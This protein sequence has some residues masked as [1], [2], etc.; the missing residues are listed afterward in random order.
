MAT[1]SEHI[2]GID[3]GTTNSSVAVV[4]DGRLEEIPVDGFRTMPSAVGLDPTGRLLVGRSAKNQQISHPEATVTSI[5]RRMGTAEKVVLAERSFSPEEISAIILGHLKSAAETHLGCP[6]TKAVITV[7]AFFNEQQRKATQAAGEL[8]GFQVMRIINEPTAAALAYGA[9]SAAR[10]GGTLLVYDLGGGTFDVSVVSI[11]NGIVEVR[12]S[13]GDTHLGGDDFDETLV[14]LA[15]KRFGSE[16]GSAAANALPRSAR[17]RLKGVMEAAKIQL[18]D[19]PFAAVSEEYL[20]A[21]HHLRTEI[22]RSAYEELIEPLIDRTLNSLQQALADAKLVPAD[23]D[24]IMLVGGAT[25]TPLVHSILRHRLGMEP[26]HEIDPDL[27]V[28]MGAAVQGAALAGQPA[29]AVL[30]DITAHGYSTECL[31]PTFGVLMC[32]PLIRR[33][34]PLP[35]RKTE[36]FSTVHA[37]QAEVEVLV[38][39]GEDPVPSRNLELGRFMV[40]GLSPTAPALSPVTICFALDLNGLLTATATEKATGLSRSVTLDTRGQHRLNLDAAR[41][42]LAA[43]FAET[44]DAEDEGDDGEDAFEEESET[45]SD[46]DGADDPSAVAEDGGPAPA[47]LL[48]SAKNLRQ[49]AEALLGR[50]LAETDAED[51]RRRLATVAEAIKN[52]SWAALQTDCD[53]LS[54]VLFYLED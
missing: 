19:E 37:G 42:N 21:S 3:L 10:D 40:E 7:P 12:A 27:I 36:V 2:V 51:I 54:D 13:H 16:H 32:V 43:L 5:K 45:E 44:T 4:V 23:V 50:G 46:N 33:G 35:V 6:V 29:P 38:Y 1:A 17:L 34:T 18:S 39:Q 47:G 22:A 25:R 14:A 20:D 11:Q 30:I 15:L 9:G 26:R 53:S 24:G 8:A 31:E 48:A 49:R 52:R 41:A 28:A